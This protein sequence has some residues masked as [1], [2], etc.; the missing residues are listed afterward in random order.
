MGPFCLMHDFLMFITQRSFWVLRVGW[1]LK[2]VKSCPC[3]ALPILCFNHLW[4]SMYGVAIVH[5][6][7]DRQ[8]DRQT[9]LLY[10]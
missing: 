1:G 10:Q 4:C 5:S 8:T 7:T 6:V 9:T 3:L 2:V